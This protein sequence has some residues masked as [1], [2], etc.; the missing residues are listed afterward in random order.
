M[1]LRRQSKAREGW[2]LQV[3]ATE[4]W[5]AALS[6]RFASA[7]LIAA[8]AWLCAV[9]GAMDALTVGQLVEREEAWIARGGYTFVVTGADREAG[10]TVPVASC[11]RL[12]DSL[13]VESS[14]AVSRSS[15]PL[16]IGGVS[17][18]RASVTSV[19][20]GIAAF[21][22]VGHDFHGGALITTGL[23]ERAG[24]SSDTVLRLAHHE[25]GS[26]ADEGS[27][28][29]IEVVS[30]DLLGAEFDGSVLL[31]D[32][33]SGLAEACYVATSA[34]YVDGVRR[35]LPSLLQHDGIPAVVAPR[36]ISGEFTIDYLWEFEHRSTRWAWLVSG[37]V[38]GVLWALT[39]WFRRAQYAVY[40]TF[41]MRGRWRLMMEMT[42]WSVVVLVG[43]GWG[44]SLGV[45]GAIAAG[46]PPVISAWYVA[47]H[48]GLTLTMSAVLAL[49]LG[50]R[51]GGDL[52]ASLKDR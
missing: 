7:L 8:V 51:S 52:L 39:R 28:T 10:A 17:S 24:L 1:I 32:L 25:A 44:W 12:A 13:A 22:G 46:A 31:P 30:A 15:D 9:P 3:C 20:P 27:V 18:R 50:V 41:G 48:S 35:A 37:S 45:V 21:L 14:V 42:E 19:S 4:G 47:V 29:P 6:G 36:L 11:H 26:G 33:L 40:V 43:V 23:A 38:V 2:S 16:V 49:V 5:R 34:A